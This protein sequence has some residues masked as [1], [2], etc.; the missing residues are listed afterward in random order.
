M[1]LENE[2][3]VGK[4]VFCIYS[5]FCSFRILPTHI[6]LFSVDPTLLGCFGDQVARKKYVWISDR[7]SYRILERTVSERHP[8]LS[9]FMKQL[10]KC[11]QMYDVRTFRTYCTYVNRVSTDVSWK[12]MKLRDLSETCT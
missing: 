5:Y 11:E 3:F 10:S 4:G 9:M 2:I 6:Q 7:W 12:M 1:N 8:K